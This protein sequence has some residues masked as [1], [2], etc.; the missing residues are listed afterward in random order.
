MAKAFETVES[1]FIIVIGHRWI[2]TKL[3]DFAVAWPKKV[4]IRE[5]WKFLP[6]M[7][8]TKTPNSWINARGQGVKKAFIYAW[9]FRSSRSYFHKSFGAVQR[10]IN[11]NRSRDRTS[12]HSLPLFHPRKLNGEL[13]SNNV[14]GKVLPIGR[15]VVQG[16]DAEMAYQRPS[17]NSNQDPSRNSKLFFGRSCKN[18]ENS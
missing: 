11:G 1:S 3:V 8:P 15:N 14:T 9:F 7:T 16:A 2:L 10:Q 18:I 13:V 17:N 5:P 12:P 4:R 6:R